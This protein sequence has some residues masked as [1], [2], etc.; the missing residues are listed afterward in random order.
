MFMKVVFNRLRQLLFTMKPSDFEDL[1]LEIFHIQAKY[2]PIYSTYIHTL[3]RSQ[4]IQRLRDIPFLPISFF[5]NTE[6]RTGNWQAEACFLSSGTTQTTRSQHFIDDLAF[7]YTL[8]AYLYEQIHGKLSKQIIYVLLPKYRAQKDSS[9]IYMLEN[10]MQHA[11]TSSAHISEI[12]ALSDTSKDEKQVLWTTTQGLVDILNSF[13]SSL[14]NYTII[15][16]GGAKKREELQPH[17]PLPV[18]YMQRERPYIYSEYGMTELCSQAYSQG[19]RHFFPPPW[20]KVHARSLH[21]P[22]SFCQ[23]EELGALNIIDLA[24]VHS[25]AFI[26]TEDLGMVKADGSFTLHGRIPQAQQRGCYVMYTG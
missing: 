20:M 16:T 18:K 1:A 22:F 10:F 21:D 23:R 25:C 26:E 11:H 7:Y 15:E 17:L 5:K 2:N 19:K 9:L 8:S 14:K 13:V 6:V 3:G 24:N 4:S 12:E